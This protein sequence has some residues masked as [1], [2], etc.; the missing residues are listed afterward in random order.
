[1]KRVVEQIFQ[2]N[3]M[4]HQKELKKNRILQNFDSYLIQIGY[5]IRNS[6]ITCFRYKMVRILISFFAQKHLILIT[7]ALFVLSIIS[8][9]KEQKKIKMKQE[10]SKERQNLLEI[11]LS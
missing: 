1:M 7:F 5:F 10:N 4:A 9:G 3:E 2:L 8:S 6:I 11:S